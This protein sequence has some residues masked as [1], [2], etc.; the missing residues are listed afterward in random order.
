MIPIGPLDH[1]FPNNL[2]YSYISKT[3]LNIDKCAL[4]I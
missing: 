2:F 1:L 3:K 4:T